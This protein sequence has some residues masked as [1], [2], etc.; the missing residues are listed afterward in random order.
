MHISRVHTDG[1]VRVSAPRHLDDEAI[2]LAVVSR[3]GW[4]HRHRQRFAE[5]ARQSQR[6][7]VS[8]ESHYFAGQ[9]YRLDV[10]IRAG[11]PAVRIRN[12]AYIE[13][14]VPP[15]TD[16]AARE[17]VLERWYRAELR[18]RIPPLLEKWGLMIGVEVGEVRIKKMKTL[19]GSC[20]IEARRIWLNL[21]LMKKPPQCLEYIL[22]HEM[23][24]LLERHHNER[25]QALMDR[26]LPDW[27]LRRDELNRAPLAHAEWEY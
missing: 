17:R 8:G 4:I 18:E 12:N 14:A 9:R 21:E 19:W 27:R 7:M 20:N 24:H 10:V 13:L 1:Q 3:L 16:R 6:E 15:D 11:R 26:F 25:F 22:V 23:V 5:Q 2:R